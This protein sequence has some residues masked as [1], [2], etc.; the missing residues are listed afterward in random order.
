MQFTIVSAVPLLVLG[1]LLATNV[2]NNG[3]S[4]MTTSPQN[5]KNNNKPTGEANFKMKG[6]MQQHKQDKER[7]RTAVL[8]VPSRS[9][10]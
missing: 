4:A 10:K 9:A 7:A 2:E 3:E 6:A 5:I 8:F 1:A